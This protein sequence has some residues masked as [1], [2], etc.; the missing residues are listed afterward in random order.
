MDGDIPIRPSRISGSVAL[1][2]APQALGG[3]VFLDFL[4]VGFPLH[5]AISA[6]V[7]ASAVCIKP[8]WQ[9]AQHALTSALCHN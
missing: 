5:E 7:A 2:E 6:S 8:D 9:V 4:E 3:F 1:N